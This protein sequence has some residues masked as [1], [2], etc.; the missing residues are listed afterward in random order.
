[1]FSTR[2]SIQNHLDR[3]TPI[4]NTNYRMLAFTVKYTFLVVQFILTFD[5]QS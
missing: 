5:L 4:L 2:H 1:M 3:S